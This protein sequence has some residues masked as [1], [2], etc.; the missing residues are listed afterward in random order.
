MTK[1]YVY[2]T[3]I[4]VLMMS[5]T[6][7]VYGQELNASDN[8]AALNNSTSNSGVNI[9]A[10]IT[11]QNSTPANV[12][13]P[14]NITT[15]PALNNA[16]LSDVASNDNDVNQIAQ[17]LST[18]G[19]KPLVAVSI[20]EIAKIAPEVA[21]GASSAQASTKQEDAYKLGSGVGGLDPFNPKHEE[22]ESLKLDLSIK[23]MRDTSKLFFVCDIV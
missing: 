1:K 8:N 9:S 21:A 17:N 7:A 12:T 18:M 6:V 16:S 10:N 5:A 20:S 2:L 4:L 3:S 22:I 13:N 14:D 23:P 15:E 19:N 11:T